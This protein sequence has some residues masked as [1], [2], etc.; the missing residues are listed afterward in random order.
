MSVQKISKVYLDVSDEGT[1]SIVL[2][3]YASHIL[4]IYPDGDTTRMNGNPQ[5][6]IDNCIAEF[7]IEEFINSVVEGYLA[8]QGKKLED[9]KIPF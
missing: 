2:V 3:T 5:A 1:P 4:K 7:S 6:I 8:G 9:F